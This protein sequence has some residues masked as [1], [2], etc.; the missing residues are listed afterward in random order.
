MWVVLVPITTHIPSFVNVAHRTLDIWLLLLLNQS[1]Y[2]NEVLNMCIQWR[3]TAWIVLV[4]TTTH[5]PS[6]TKIGHCILIREGLPFWLTSNLYTYIH[7]RQHDKWKLR[8]PS[9]TADSPQKVVMFWNDQQIYKRV[10][11]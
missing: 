2:A 11:S 9:S 6:F 1:R 5:I 10:V 8:G 4:P 7:G 3:Q